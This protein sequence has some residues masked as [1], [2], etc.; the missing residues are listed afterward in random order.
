MEQSVKSARSV[1]LQFNLFEPRTPPD[2]E[3]RESRKTSWP[4]R[5]ANRAAADFVAQHS[6]TSLT[7]S[8]SWAGALVRVSHETP[9]K[10]R[11]DTTSESPEIATPAG[12][13]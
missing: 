2:R 1:L 4:S 11:I 10:T 9:K 3:P 12:K 6:I 5:T 13:E 7:S 8:S